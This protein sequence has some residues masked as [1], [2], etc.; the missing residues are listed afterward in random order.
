M[1]GRPPL[2]PDEAYV[3][4]DSR[5]V[6]TRGVGYPLD[7]IFCDGRWRV[8]H[9]ETL[10]PMSRSAH[11]GGAVNVIELLGGRAAVHGI[12]PGTVLSFGRRRRGGEAAR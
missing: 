10:Q 2:D 3:I 11:V 9:V 7:A 6:H 4:T 8:L 1:L 12:V 5:R